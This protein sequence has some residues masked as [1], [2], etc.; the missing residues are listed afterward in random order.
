MF[1]CFLLMCY[2]LCIIITMVL[3]I[4]FHNFSLV[5]EFKLVEFDLHGV[6]F[7][8]VNSLVFA[9]EFFELK[10]SIYYVVGALRLHNSKQQNVLVYIFNVTEM[11][12]F[13]FNVVLHTKGP[14]SW[15]QNLE[16]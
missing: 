4:L 15:M 11:H 7:F 12:T 1:F 6:E 13:I 8:L 14:V 3:L 2:P 16:T 9:I 10:I 5:T